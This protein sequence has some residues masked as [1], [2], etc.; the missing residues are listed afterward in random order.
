MYLVPPAA[1]AKDPRERFTGDVDLTPLHAGDTVHT[2]P[3]EEHWHGATSDTVMCHLALAEHD[4]RIGA[5]W[6]EA[7]TDQDYET[8]HALASHQPHPSMKE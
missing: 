3:E 6:G 4:D 5:T 8:A 2:P 1:T 7:V